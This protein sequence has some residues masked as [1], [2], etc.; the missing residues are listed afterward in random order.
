MLTLQTK[1]ETPLPLKTFSPYYIYFGYNKDFA[2]S[3]EEAQKKASQYS[4]EGYKTF[5]V[6]ARP[7]LS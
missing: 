1:E 2:D 4:L 6:K 3:F 5:I 7:A